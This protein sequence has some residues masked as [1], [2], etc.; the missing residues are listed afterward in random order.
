MISDN[1]SR[2]PTFSQDGHQRRDVLWCEYAKKL[3]VFFFCHLFREKEQSFQGHR[4]RILSFYEWFLTPVEGMALR[5]GQP[6]R[7]PIFCL[8]SLHPSFLLSNAGGVCLWL[9]LFVHC[10]GSS[11]RCAFPSLQLFRLL[12]VPNTGIFITVLSAFVTVYT[13]AGPRGNLCIN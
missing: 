3:F 6:R 13:S 8:L 10:Q 12:S 7:G 2:K 5:R 1:R 4:A 11:T 9:L